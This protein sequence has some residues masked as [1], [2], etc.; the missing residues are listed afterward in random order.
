MTHNAKSD[1]ID[2]ILESGNL[3]APSFAITKKDYEVDALSKFGD[4]TFIRKPEKIKFGSDN[5]YNRDIYSPRM[6]RPEYQL[7]DGTVIDSYE[8]EAQE[9]LEKEKPEK[10]KERFDKPTSER[11]KDAK[12][13]MFLGYTPSGNRRYK[14]YTAENII[15][16]MKKEGLL[17]G[18]NFDYGLSSLMSR[19]ATKQKSMEELKESAK[20]G[21]YSSKQLNEDYENL[22]K[23]YEELGDKVAPLY[24]DKYSF[25]EFQSDVFFAIA[26]NKKKY[27]KDTYNIEVPTELEKEVKDFVKKA[28]TLPR[29]Y[30]EAKPMREVS[31]DEFGYAI[32]RIGTLTNSQR[33]K[34]ENVYHIDVIE[35]EDNIKEALEQVETEQPE[36]YFQTGINQ[37]EITNIDGSI[38]EDV[39]NPLAYDYLNNQ[40]TGEKI[41]IELN[42]DIKVDKIESQEISSSL[43]FEISQKPSN[44]KK[45]LIKSLNLGNNKALQVKNINTNEVVNIKDKTIEKSLSNVRIS[46]EHYKD[47]CTILYNV[48]NLFE[49]SQ[50]I[51]GYNDTKKVSDLKISRYANVAKVNNNEYLLEF[52][53]KDNGEVLLYSVDLLD[54]RKQYR[55]NA[56]SKN[57]MHHDTVNNSIAHIQDTIKSKLVQKYNNDYKNAYKNNN[58]EQSQKRTGYVFQG[59]AQPNLFVE[60]AAQNHNKGFIGIDLKGN[61]G[62]TDIDRNLILIGTTGDITTVLHESAHY[63]LNMLEELERVP[64]HSPKV[65][66]ALFAIRKTLKNDGTPFTRSQHEKFAKGFEHYIYTGNARNNLFK[67]IY[68]DIKNLLKNIYEFVQKGQYFTTGEGALTEEEMK[69]FNN[70]FDEI[71]KLENKT[72]KERVF[73]K[74]LALDEKEEDGFFKKLTRFLSLFWQYRHLCHNS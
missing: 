27:L 2:A 19:F 30:F 24:W 23:E 55:E 35:Y 36:I 43:P 47:F 15:A 17:S 64:D 13:V 56:S 49:T 58:L 63:F 31:L 21:L 61:R 45:A 71:F 22:K 38:V 5:I 46:D 34:L 52:V 39:T 33:E 3:I 10:Y 54:K 72:V 44:N 12:K 28:Q 68:E 66:D 62:L 65:D 16:Q 40:V 4:V 18:E 42:T 9:R 50:K 69:N 41:N 20:D 26:K 6:P 8:K 37:G 60:N 11:F 73:A 53:S 32:A 29:S 59:P 67:E 74:V 70:V 7:K 51:L 48:K 25:Y 1:N 57:S 14:P